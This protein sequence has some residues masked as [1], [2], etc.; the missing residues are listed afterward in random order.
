MHN[1]RLFPDL[2]Q[3]S[4]DPTSD[5]GDADTTERNKYAA[6]V[7]IILKATG[8][9]WSDIDE[10]CRRLKENNLNGVTLPEERFAMVQEVCNDFLQD[11]EIRLL[12]VLHLDGSLQLPRESPASNN[13]ES[14]LPSD[15]NGVADGID[16]AK[17]L[18]SLETWKCLETLA[19]VAPVTGGSS[20]T[21]SPQ[22][23]LDQKDKTPLNCVSPVEALLPFNH[24]DEGEQKFLDLIDQQLLFLR[25]KVR[26]RACFR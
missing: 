16:T 15:Y 21:G 18:S 25:P 19:D 7:E 23:L 20:L 17:A 10:I 12:E 5:Q 22:Q 11:T 2:S 1:L 6:E 8:N 26:H 13:Y 14:S 9:W 3:T 4:E 24:R